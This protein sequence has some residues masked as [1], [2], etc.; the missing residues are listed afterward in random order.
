[1]PTR[2]EKHAK[3]VEKVAAAETELTRAFNKWQKLRQ[4]LRRSEKRLDIELAERHSEIA[5]KLDIRDIT[6]PTKPHL[7][8]D[9]INAATEA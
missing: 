9:P 5:G 7:V 4:Q 2:E 8:E 3:L 1:M 6:P